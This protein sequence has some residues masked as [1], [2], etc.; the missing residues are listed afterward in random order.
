MSPTKQKTETSPRDDVSEEYEDREGHEQSE[1]NDLLADEIEFS[2]DE[3]VEKD[4]GLTIKN[5]A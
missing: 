1:Y 2:E 4:G 5:A 3:D